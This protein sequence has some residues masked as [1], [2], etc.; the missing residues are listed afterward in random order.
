MK[1]N[2]DYHVYSVNYCSVV[3]PKELWDDCENYNVPSELKAC[4][5]D[6]YARLKDG[7]EVTEDN[8]NELVNSSDFKDIHQEWQKFLK[9]VLEINADTYIFHN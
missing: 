7:I 2:F 6:C 4:A 9:E 3:V 8:L 5:V 1:T